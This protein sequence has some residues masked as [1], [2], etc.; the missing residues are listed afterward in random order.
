MW[1]EEDDLYRTATTRTAAVALFSAT[2]L[3]LPRTDAIRWWAVTPAALLLVAGAVVA[4]AWGRGR[5]PA[6]PWVIA[7]SHQALTQTGA[8]FAGVAMGGVE[9]NQR[10]LPMLVLVLTASYSPAVVVAIGWGIATA[11]IFWSAVASGLEA[12][13]AFTVT[14]MFGASAASVASIVHMLL[15]R[16]R[17]QNRQARLT[18]TLAASVAR[19][20]SFD[21]QLP[22]ILALTSSLLGGAS[23]ALSRVEPERIVV[24]LGV[25]EP[26]VR[27]DRGPRRRK[28]LGFEEEVLVSVVGRVPYVLL[29]GWPSLEVRRRVAP[30]NVAIVRD[31]LGHFVERAAHIARL[32][33]R[34]RT[35]PLTGLGNRRALAAWLREHNSTATVVM[36]DLDHFK[37]FNDANGHVAGDQLL[38]RFGAVVRHQLRIG[39]C[40]V[41]LG[42]EEFCVAL[43]ARDEHLG[44]RF[45][46]RLRAA[47]RADPGG[48]TF[49]AG[50]AVGEP[51]E[52]I[53]QVLARADAALYEAKRAGRNRTIVAS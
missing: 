17:R 6:W 15:T 20:D 41:R 18:A 29:I 8:G 44:V 25:H 3:L 19:A 45:V 39:D 52:P 30:Q 24:P 34:T 32:E 9:G 36:L 16:I 27:R 40:A 13:I 33:E 2:A 22:E 53:D 43:E 35:D 37:S 46:E 42:G 26:P 38:R 28:E 1:R 21:E 10:F 50:I 14:V 51:G 12:G 48:V 49:S 47:F 7:V 11:T 31:L 4:R 5:H 23:V